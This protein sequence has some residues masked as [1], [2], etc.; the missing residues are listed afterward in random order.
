M[1]SSSVKEHVEKEE[2]S[3]Y[4]GA[5]HVATHAE[6]S[7]TAKVY[8]KRMYNWVLK[9]RTFVP[10]VSACLRNVQPI[11]E[12]LNP[13]ESWAGLWPCTTHLSNDCTQESLETIL[14]RQSVA[15][16]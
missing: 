9:H 4:I 3:E 10:L 13:L 2:E 7:I 5:Q 8:L 16:K 6:E 14:G 11:L 15:R 1:L 12:C